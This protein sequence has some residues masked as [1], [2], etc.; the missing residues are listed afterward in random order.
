MAIEGCEN[1]RPR[2][3]DLLLRFFSK[4]VETAGSISVR[5]RINCGLVDAQNAEANPP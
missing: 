3:S 5:V 1:N 4:I 2:N